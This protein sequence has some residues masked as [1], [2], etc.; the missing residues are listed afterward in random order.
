MVFN[1]VKICEISIE[2]DSSLGSRLAFRR[3]PSRSQV[4]IAEVGSFGQVANA[5]KDR[6]PVSAVPVSMNTI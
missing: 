5:R 1:F 4:R 6:M 2:S 3:L